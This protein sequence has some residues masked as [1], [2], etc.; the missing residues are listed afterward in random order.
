[1]TGWLG[2]FNKQTST[3]NIGN[4]QKIIKKTA[5]LYVYFELK[6]YIYQEHLVAVK[7]LNEIKLLW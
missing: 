6:T 5:S 4:K 1:M 7:Q 2:H 3:S